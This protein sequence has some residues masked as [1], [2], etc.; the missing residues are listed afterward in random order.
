[1]S[2]YPKKLYAELF[3]LCAA[4]RNC[5]QSGNAEWDN[6]HRNSID[7]LSENYLPSGSGFDT[8]TTVNIDD[9]IKR[10]N[11]RRLTECLILETSYHHM[12]DG[13]YYT[14]WSEHTVKVFPSL[15]FGFDL[16]VSGQNKN[17]IVDYI[18]DEFSVMLDAEVWQTSDGVWHNSMYQKYSDFKQCMYCNGLFAIEHTQ[19]LQCKPNV[20]GGGEHT[21]CDKCMN[22]YTDLFAEV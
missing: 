17:D 6:K 3:S 21:F 9:T 14:H 13:G 1:M 10:M 19:T 4:I 12:N 15:Q 7:R 16:K 22:T 8:G 2:I 11:N 20:L 18:A 5:Q